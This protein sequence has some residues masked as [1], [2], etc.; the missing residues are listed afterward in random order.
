MGLKLYQ[1]AIHEL[2]ADDTWNIVNFVSLLK[3]VQYTKANELRQPQLVITVISV[4]V[5]VCDVNP[6]GRFKSKK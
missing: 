5:S 2:A 4:S 6:R 1:K 3:I